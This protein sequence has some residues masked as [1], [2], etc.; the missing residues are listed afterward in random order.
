[1]ESKYITFDNQF[2]HTVALNCLTDVSS[3][4]HFLNDLFTIYESEDSNKTQNIENIFQCEPNLKQESEATILS[5]F[6]YGIIYSRSGIQQTTALPQNAVLKIYGF[7]TEEH[8]ISS[9]KEYSNNHDILEHQISEMSVPY[10]QELYERLLFLDSPNED[11]EDSPMLTGSLKHF[12]N[13]IKAHVPLYPDLFLTPDG[14]VR[15][16][17]FQD[18]KHYFFAEF[19]PSGFVRYSCGI[20]SKKDPSQVERNQ[21]K[22]SIDKLIP[23]ILSTNSANW[24]LSGHHPR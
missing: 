12:L 14:L 5:N 10:K 18:R 4:T 21:G 1:M 7:N 6:V 23:T 2:T 24:C 19:L 13:F 8:N 11:P 9:V 22:I 15:S 16:E 20:Q 3:G 17:W